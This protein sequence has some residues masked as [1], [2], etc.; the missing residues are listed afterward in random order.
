M[1]Y[2]FLSYGFGYGLRPKA[3]VFQGQTFGYRRRWKLRLRSNTVEVSNTVLWNWKVSLNYLGWILLGLFVCVWSGHWYSLVVLHNYMEVGLFRLACS[4][5]LIVV[6][7]SNAIAQMVARPSLWVKKRGCG[8]KPDTTRNLM[9]E[10]V[11][12]RDG[13]TKQEIQ[14][15]TSYIPY[16]KQSEI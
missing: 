10:Q 9:D 12:I 14:A 1:F 6:S 16:L 13:H 11:I 3:E 7:K 5:Y 2:N 4:L 15:Y 8:F